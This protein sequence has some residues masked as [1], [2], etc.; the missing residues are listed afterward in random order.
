MLANKADATDLTALS[1]TVGTGAMSVNGAV[2][3]TVINAINA[4]DSKT[5][6]IA[7]DENLSELQDNVTELATFVG[8]ADMGTTAESVTGA[9]GEH[10][11]AIAGL[12]TAVDAKQDTLVATGNNANIVGSGSVTVSKDAD[13]G[14]I[15]ING[16]DNDTTYALGTAETL[17]LT[18]LYSGV[19]TANDGTMTQNAIKTA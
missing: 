12:E 3:S 16:T 9:I 4:L 14:V 1:N 5:N 13:T 6:G 7:T 8:N 10:T 11:T 15:P 17:G 2:Q 18:K 19:G